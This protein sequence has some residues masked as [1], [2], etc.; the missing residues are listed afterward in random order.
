MVRIFKQNRD[1]KTNRIKTKQK[2]NTFIARYCNF[3]IAK[4]DAVTGKKFNSE[5]A[6]R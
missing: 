6:R 2:R 5:I 1:W 3:I 4:F